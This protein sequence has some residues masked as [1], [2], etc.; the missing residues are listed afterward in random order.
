[1]RRLRFNICL[2]LIGV[3]CW[4]ETAGKEPYQQRLEKTRTFWDH[5]IPSHS[6]IQYA[7]GIGLLSAGLGWD[8]GRSNQWETDVMLGFVPSYSTDKAKMTFTL[9]QSYLPWNSQ[10]VNEKFTFDP[11]SVG[12]AV[13][14][15]FDNEFW[16][17]EPDKYPSRYYGF[18]TKLRLWLHLGQCI[19]LHIP[20]EKR[21]MAKSIT[22]FYE[23]SSCDLYMVSAFTNSH[24]K[25]NDYLRLAVGLKFQ[26]Y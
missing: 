18:S 1:M 21:F 26:I 19:T 15:V 24:L 12:L 17:T 11:L 10:P 9:K 13:N 4:G 2:L 8:Y 20:E 25:P 3:G 7:G 23:V 6:K 22:A 5:L 16:I 14:T